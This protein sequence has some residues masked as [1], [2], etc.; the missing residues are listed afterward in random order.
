[1]CASWAAGTKESITCGCKPER[2]GRGGGKEY[3]QLLQE[4]R[5]NTCRTFFESSLTSRLVTTN[6]TQWKD[7]TACQG[8]AKKLKTPESGK[9]LVGNSS[10]AYGKTNCE[11]RESN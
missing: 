5:G 2:T 4:D 8:T 7:S 11:G 3:L 1:M 9:T 10:N 6:P